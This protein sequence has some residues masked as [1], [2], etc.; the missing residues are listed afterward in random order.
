MR[1]LLTGGGG[2]LGAAIIKRLLGRNIEVR[3]LDANDSR[4]L[5]YRV[6]GSAMRKVEWHL[7]PARIVWTRFCNS[8]GLS[9]GISLA[10]FEG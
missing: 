6:V 8:G 4:D 5:G 3:V 9:Y 7:V 10:G 2:F 1:V